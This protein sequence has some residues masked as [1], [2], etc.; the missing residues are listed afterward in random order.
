VS[1]ESR[2]REVE[3]KL[4]K[5]CGAVIKAADDLLEEKKYITVNAEKIK[6]KSNKTSRVDP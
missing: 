2:K 6:K 1:G 4:G 3:K 5:R